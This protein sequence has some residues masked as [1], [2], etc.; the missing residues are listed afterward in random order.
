MES[1]Q[2]VVL[3][4]GASSGIGEAVALRLAHEGHYVVAGARRRERLAALAGRHDN[5]RVRRLDVTDRGD[6][7]AF[8]DSAV[9]EFGRVDVL[10]NNAGL[11]PLSRLDALLVDEWDQM[12]D[13]NVRGL[14]HGIAAVL[15]VFQRQGSGHLVTVA[16]VGAHEVVP[17]SAVYSATKFA[18]WA[19]TEGLRLEADP[20]LRVTTITPGVVESELAETISDPVAREA[21]REYRKNSIS[22][23]AIARAISFAV[24]QP[25]D[26]DINEIIIRPTR[27]RG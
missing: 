20:S 2:K 10:V 9:A 11:M 3:V 22:P 1:T 5:I 27:Q 18:A 21:M 26:V 13:V 12:L 4:T 15:P 8:V 14:L 24:D 6:V 7:A 16:S 25:A 17:T 19:I 23:D